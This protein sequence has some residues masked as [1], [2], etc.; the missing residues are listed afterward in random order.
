MRNARI[1]RL[2]Q[3]NKKETCFSKVPIPQCPEGY[4]KTESEP[5]ELEFHCVPTE[6]ESTKRLIKLH[7]TKPLEKMASKRTDRIEEIEAELECQQL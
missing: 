3:F 7:K 5:R 1:T 2:N 4:T 6:L